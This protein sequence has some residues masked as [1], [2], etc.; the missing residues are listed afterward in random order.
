MVMSGNTELAGDWH[1]AK[2]RID[3]FDGVLWVACA[4]IDDLT[5]TDLVVG[6][7]NGGIDWYQ[8]PGTFFA[9]GKWRRFQAA[10]RQMAY[11]ADAH[12]VSDLDQD[13]DPEIVF[14]DR[15]SGKLASSCCGRWEICRF[16]FAETRCLGMVV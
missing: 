16:S 10:D 6:N 2:H 4:Q 8:A 9:A 11:V 3:T 7:E 12:L 13:S 14:N 5:T 1:T 15:R